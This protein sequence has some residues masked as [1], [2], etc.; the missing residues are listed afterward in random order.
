MGFFGGKKPETNTPEVA[1]PAKVARKQIEPNGEP[2]KDSSYLASGLV[3]EGQLTGAIP[4]HIDGTFSGTI[5]C[6]TRICV[7]N[8]GKVEAEIHCRSIVIEGEVHGNIKA[9]E[10]IRI[11]ASGVLKGDIWTKTFINQPGGFFE[12]YS[13]MKN[14]TSPS[15]TAKETKKK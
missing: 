5:D 7:G 8:Q 11:E 9:T 3:L 14:E 15:A 13:H 4:L 6:P 10:S 2:A 1:K 12:G